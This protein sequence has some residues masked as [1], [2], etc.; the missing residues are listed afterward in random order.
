M[1]VPVTVT[2]KMKAWPS[3]KRSRSRSALAS[4]PNTMAVPCSANPSRTRKAR[5]TP[6]FLPSVA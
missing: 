4:G 5:S 1:M 3:P 6:S 2:A